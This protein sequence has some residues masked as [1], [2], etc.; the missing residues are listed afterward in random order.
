MT[1]VI[2]SG[3]WVGEPGNPAAC[4]RDPVVREWMQEASRRHELLLERAGIG[5]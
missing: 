1:G 3:E 2:A 5:S 4:L